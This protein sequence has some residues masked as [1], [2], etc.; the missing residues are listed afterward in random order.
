ME[1]KFEATEAHLWLEEIISGDRSEDINAVWKHLDIADWYAE[2]IETK[3]QNQFLASPGCTFAQGYFYNKPM[4]VSEISKL[5]RDDL[6]ASD[7]V[8]QDKIVSLFPQG[9]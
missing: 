6:S 1:I 5:L 2:G 3:E 8:K 7:R 4:P 9:E